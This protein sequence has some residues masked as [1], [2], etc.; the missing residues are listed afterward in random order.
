MDPRS[1][2][3]QSKSKV[4]DVQTLIATRSWRALIRPGFGSGIGMSVGIQAT[5]GR[6]GS[7]VQVLVWVWATFLCQSAVRFKLK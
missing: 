1:S 5:A 3:S 2:E 4:F 7:D 6:D